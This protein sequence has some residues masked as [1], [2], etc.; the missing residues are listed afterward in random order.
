VLRDGDPEQQIE[1]GGE[2][3]QRQAAA[4]DAQHVV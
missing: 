2:G 1:H 4:Q 3:A